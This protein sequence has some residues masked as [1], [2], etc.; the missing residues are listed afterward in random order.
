MMLPRIVYLMSVHGGLVVGSQAKIMAG[1][2]LGID[3]S[4]AERTGSDWDVLV[5]HEHWQKIALIIPEDAR[6]NKFGGWRFNDDKGNEI[7]VWPGSL[8]TYL[9]ECKTKYGGSVYAVDYIHNMIYSSAVRDLSGEQPA[10]ENTKALNREG[11]SVP[12]VEN[13]DLDYVKSGLNYIS[14]K[15][16]ENIR[17]HGRR[18]LTPLHQDDRDRWKV[19]GELVNELKRNLE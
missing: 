11:A 5:P 10:D 3:E 14:S 15:I 9:S 4:G 1:D 6:P 19:L 18:V 17:V 8:H 2:S 13:A 16:E 7:D 12:Y